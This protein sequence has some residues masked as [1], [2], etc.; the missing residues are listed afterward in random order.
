MFDCLFVYLWF[1][2]MYQYF[3]VVKC[4]GCD[5]VDF[6]FVKYYSKREDS[7]VNEFIKWL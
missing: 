3:V 2:V 1:Y 4:D 5:V 7:F 6:Y